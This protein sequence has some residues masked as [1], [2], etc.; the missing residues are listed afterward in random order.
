[1]LRCLGPCGDRQGDE[2]PIPEDAEGLAEAGKH[3]EQQRHGHVGDLGGHGQGEDARD[4]LQEQSKDHHGQPD[5]VDL[6]DGARRPHAARAQQQGGQGGGKAMRRQVGEP[7]V[8]DA[9]GAMGREH[10]IVCAAH[11]AGGLTRLAA[12]QRS[13]EPGAAAEEHCCQSSGQQQPKD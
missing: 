13:A 4:G 5:H 9:M 1:M 7:H 3:R 2:E 8:V 10:L 6:P 11:G 12:A